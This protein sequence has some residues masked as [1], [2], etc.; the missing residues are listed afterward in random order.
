MKQA[1]E[2][3]AGNHSAHARQAASGWVIEGLLHHVLRRSHP[4]QASR[5][6]APALD[7]STSPVS[8][9]S[10][11]ILSHRQTCTAPPRTKKRKL[12]KEGLRGSP[13]LC[14]SREPPEYS[15]TGARDR[16]TIKRPHPT[17]SLYVKIC[18]ASSTLGLLNYT[19]ARAGYD[20]ENDTAAL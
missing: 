14:K 5:P 12:S 16:E 9:I 8:I 15:T 2:C 1:I 19:R 3:E 7:S 18:S 4:E 13:Q 11:Y 17:Q 20:R 10:I 6:A